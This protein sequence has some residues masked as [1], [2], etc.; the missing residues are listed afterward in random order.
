M[1]N[2]T[3]FNL[4]DV[5]AVAAEDGKENVLGYLVWYSVETG[6]K[7]D[8]EKAAEAVVRRDLQTTPRKVLPF[9][10]WQRITRDEIHGKRFFLPTGERVNLLLRSVNEE[11]DVAERHVVREIVDKKGRRLSVEPV[12]VLTLRKGT[13]QFGVCYKTEVE[14]EIKDYIAMARETFEDEIYYFD[15]QWV[16]RVI[17]KEI[18]L[19]DGISFKKTGGINFIPRSFADNFANLQGF[20]EEINVLVGREA[21][22]LASI[23]LINTA[24]HK[25]LLNKAVHQYVSDQFT[26]LTK[27]IAAAKQSG[28]EMSEDVIM[29]FMERFT[30]LKERVKRYMALTQTVSQTLEEELNLARASLGTL[31]SA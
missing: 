24:E 19:M 21:V 28:K 11:S 14:E 3:L 17:A 5:V 15:G 30:E 31:L 20:V 16:R 10:A 8:Q 29:V 12:A 27:D 4:E 26:R 9:H 13:N 7:V 6:L 1:T 18:R 25:E 2:G 23:M 22:E